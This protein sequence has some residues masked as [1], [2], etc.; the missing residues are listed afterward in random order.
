[1]GG[2]SS[3]RQTKGHATI[4]IVEEPTK[5]LRGALA[6]VTRRKLLHQNPRPS[7]TRPSIRTKQ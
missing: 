7:Q 1:M 5:P 3:S 6:L 2:S 4:S